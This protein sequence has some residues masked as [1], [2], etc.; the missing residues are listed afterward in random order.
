MDRKRMTV[1]RLFD[2]KQAEE[3]ITLITAYDYT[4]AKCLDAAEIDIVL[5][6][7][8]LGQV[9]LGYNTTLQVTLDDVIHHTK[10]VARGIEYALILADMPFMTYQVNSDLALINAGR[11]MQEGNAHSVKLEGGQEIAPTIKKIVD[12]GIPV[13][14]HIGFTPQSYFKLGGNRIQGRSEADAKK[15]I[16]DAKALEDAGVFSI[17]LELIPAEL[18]KRITEAVDVPT[19]GIGAGIH[20]DGQVQVSHDILGLLSDFKPKHAKRYKN[21]ADEITD[22][23][24]QFKSDV[25]QGIFPADENSF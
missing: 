2:K 25:S 13:M 1:K 22:A 3:K 12:A 6:G 23:F 20:C 17:V 11:L 15:M 24:K 10:A 21:I 7:D 8:S 16:A 18:A 19:L 14:G 9:V 5:I 4:T